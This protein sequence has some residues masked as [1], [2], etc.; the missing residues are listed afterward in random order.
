MTSNDNSRGDDMENQV[1][2][3]DT[4]LMPVPLRLAPQVAEYLAGLSTGTVT[5]AE[6]A[7]TSGSTHS[8]TV[9]GQGE[10]TP[11]MIA[12]LSDAT[13]YAGVVALL[14]R[15]AQSPGRWILKADV[16]EALGISAVQLRNELGAFSKLT[17][18]L[19]GRAIWPMQYKKQQGS[20]YYRMDDPAARWWLES[21]DER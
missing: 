16:E 13:P 1:W 8:L 14:D 9:P 15:C 19:F 21:R 3:A 18:R 17:K 20:Y 4:V 11:A 10:W 7:P 12:D 2:G 6:G 5:R